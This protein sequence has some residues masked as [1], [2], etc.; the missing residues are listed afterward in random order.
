MAALP[1][2]S[3]AIGRLEE[4]PGVLA[5]VRAGMEIAVERAED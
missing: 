4:D 3:R 2:R 1:I 5:A